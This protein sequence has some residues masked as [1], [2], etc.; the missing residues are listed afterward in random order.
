MAATS[1]EVQ[2]VC[3][4]TTLVISSTEK[5]ITRNAISKRNDLH[6][7]TLVPSLL[8]LLFYTPSGLS[9]DASHHVRFLSYVET[10]HEVSLVFEERLLAKFPEG[11]LE[12]EQL[13]WKALQVASAGAGAFLSQL[14]VL[15]QL[16]TELAKHGI[17]VFQ[18][19]TYQSDYGESVACGN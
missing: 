19:S 3:L 17:S 11:A 1:A 16:T 4:S 8:E 13:R 7:L 10:Q 12:F 9:I 18:I 6:S 14:A 5:T 2:L 15:I